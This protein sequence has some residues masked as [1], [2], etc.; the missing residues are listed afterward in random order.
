MGEKYKALKEAI[1]KAY[2]QKEGDQ[3]TFR[4]PDPAIDYGAR[5]VVS[6]DGS[7]SMSETATSSVDR[8][9][10]QVY[11]KSSGD[12]EVQVYVGSRYTDF[13]T[14]RF[15]ELVAPPGR[16]DRWKKITFK[17]KVD[18]AVARAR[19]YLNDLQDP[20]AERNAIV[21]AYNEENNLAHMKKM[22]ELD[23][24][25]IVRSKPLIISVPTADELSKDFPSPGIVTDN[26]GMA[27]MGYDYTNF[28]PPYRKI[29][30]EAKDEKQENK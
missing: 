30:G 24:G 28:A 8:D 6:Y 13:G 29:L 1:K 11:V 2:T 3:L 21:D 15:K 20:Q 22:A 10:Q 9:K 18:A 17:M 23:K 16:I 27:G 7:I 12:T 19:K 25:K 4:L 14:A 26:S 5:V